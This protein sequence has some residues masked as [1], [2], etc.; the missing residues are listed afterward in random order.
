MTAINDAAKGWSAK[1]FESGHILTLSSTMSL[2]H[3][4]MEEGR[5]WSIPINI[6]T[7]ADTNDNTVFHL[8]N[9]SDDYF[10]FHKIVFSANGTGVFSLSTGLSYSSGG[11]LITSKPLNTA[12]GQKA[13]DLSYYGNN[14]IETGTQTKISNFRSQANQNVDLLGGLESLGLGPSDTISIK[15]KNDAS[16]AINLVGTLFFHGTEPWD[17]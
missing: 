15:F 9:E 3:T 5:A 16:T 6:T 12:S 4:M 2:M 7:I 17:E 10:D 8:K 14:I 13:S 1:V 11:T